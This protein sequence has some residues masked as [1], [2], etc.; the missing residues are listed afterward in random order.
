[1]PDLSGFARRPCA[2][3]ARRRSGRGGGERDR[4]GG[5]RNVHADTGELR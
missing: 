2:L 3:A 4:I 5:G 1:M